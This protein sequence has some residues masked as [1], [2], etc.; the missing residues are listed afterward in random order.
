M[1]TLLF[2][3]FLGGGVAV[4]QQSDSVPD[5]RRQNKLERKDQR[6][7]RQLDRIEKRNPN[8]YGRQDNRVDRKSQRNDRRQVRTDQRVNRRRTTPQSN[9]TSWRIDS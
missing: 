8:G 2:A 1:L 4:A 3:G 5:T 6:L 7:E 9:Y